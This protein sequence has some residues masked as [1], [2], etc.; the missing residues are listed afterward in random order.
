MSKVYDAEEF[1]ARA[2]VKTRKVWF[3]L[4]LLLTGQYYSNVT[5]GTYE[6]RYIVPFLLLCWV[7]YIAGFIYLKIKG[8]NASFYR[9]IITIGYGLF[10]GYI[11]CTSQTMLS[12]AYIF[13]VA[14]MI[15]LFKDRKFMI[16]CGVFNTVILIIAS[17]YKYMTGMNSV[18]DIDNYM[19]QISC[20]MLSYMC[21]VMSINHLNLSDGALTDSIKDDLD[22]VVKTVEQVK[23]SSNMIVDGITVVRE[24]EEEN[25]QGANFVV[26]SMEEL[27]R[28]N[29][30][31]HDKTNSSTDMTTKINN[32]VENVAALIN[33]VVKLVSGSV[34][35]ADLSSKELADV[36][37]STD[38]MAKLSGE[39]DDILHEFQQEFEKVKTETGT[40][41]EINSQ[42][43]LLALNASI[44]AARAG[45]AGKG[46]AVVADEIR[47][48]SDE[49][50]ESSDRIMAA[51]GHLGDTSGRM[52]ESVKRILSIIQ[53]TQGKVV[54]VNDSV[55]GIAKD[56]NQIGQHI[57]V[58]D[59]AMQEVESSNRNLVDNMSQIESVMQVI[60]DCITN[61][62]DS[63][64][65]M[66]SKYEESSRNVNEIESVVGAMM[67]KLGNGG[68]MG[69]QDIKPGMR[70][71][72][73]QLVSGKP[74]NR[75]YSGEII[76]QKGG[77]LFV[78]FDDEDIDVNNPSLKFRIEIVAGNVLYHW[79]DVSA[80]RAA[81]YKED[82]CR[83][84]VSTLP[85]I[86]NRRKYTRMPIHNK[87]SIVFEDNAEIT[88]TGEMVNISAN[89]FAF[90]TRDKE[91]A[92]C[93]GKNMI[94]S[95]PDFPVE[96]GRLIEGVAIRSTDSDG[97]YIVGCRMPSDSIEIGNYVNRNYSE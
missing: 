47:N 30:I 46:F 32:Q 80:K 42:T 31:L 96:Q 9:S 78:R 59:S 25:R 4:N 70:C 64:K 95:I 23:D 2:N 22:R 87:C 49:T 66:L 41:E 54:K 63:T 33:D 1:K 74:S 77:A 79:T 88:F 75:D 50:Q 24:L 62:D 20:I 71:T 68:F 39:V 97:S 83:L 43:N 56:S 93:N 27:S 73:R 15:I 60:Q 5:K 36:V 28:N 53:E 8:K 85:S 16:K 69:I 7:P 72:V 13:P 38:T 3:I 92:D 89:G 57:G 58:V 61:A 29:D 94:V 17:V 81:E 76:A 67:E 65:I 34:E 48:L 21:Y 90:T 12:F 19:L 44:E 55:A 11:V 26:S 82:V 91:F 18:A 51:L 86:V 45:E 6:Q 40:I 37:E 35:H 52:L 10:Y 14:S 84:E